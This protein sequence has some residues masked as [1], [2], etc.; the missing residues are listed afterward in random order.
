VDSVALDNSKFCK[1][2]G[3]TKDL[4]LFNRR[5]DYKGPRAFKSKCKTCEHS[6]YVE[7]AKDPNNRKRFTANAR[8]WQGDNPLRAR[9]LICRANAL[10]GN[11]RKILAFELSFEDVVLLWS[12]GCHY[13]SVPILGKKG[14]GLDRIDN[15]IGYIKGNVLPCCGD[16]NKV[17]NTVFSVGEMETAMKAV[18]EYR[19]QFKKE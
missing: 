1:T 13:C 16:C 18:L 14:V 12:S 8:R 6:R 2:C 17:R 11:R 4:S 5:Y 9:F 15:S 10:N 3:L 19:K 7:A